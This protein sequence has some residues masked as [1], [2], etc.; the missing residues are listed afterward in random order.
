MSTN[1][2]GDGYVQHH[3]G[4]HPVI[5][6][7]DP[8]APAVSA[9]MFIWKRG[10]IGYANGTV[11]R[12]G[13][14]GTWV[15]TKERL[16]TLRLYGTAAHRAVDVNNAEWS[17]GAD[18]E[19]NISRP[20]FE[21]K[22]PAAPAPAETQDRD[23][24]EGVDPVID[25][26]FD[27]VWSKGADEWWRPERVSKA[28]MNV[29]LFAPNGAG[30][31]AGP[32]PASQS[33]ENARPQTAPV[34]CATVSGWHQEL[35]EAMLAHP[36]LVAA[37][38]PEIAQAAKRS[39]VEGTNAMSSSGAVIS[40]NCKACQQQVCD[41]CQGASEGAVSDVVL[42][43]SEYIDRSASTTQ[44]GAGGASFMSEDE[45]LGRS[46]QPVKGRL[47][48][49]DL[50]NGIMVNPAFILA[51]E[52]GGLA[53]STGVRD[54]VTVL[55]SN[56]HQYRFDVPFSH[57]QAPYRHLQPHERADIA[58]LTRRRIL[59]LLGSPGHYATELEMPP[60][61][62]VSPAADSPFYTS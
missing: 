47:D 26:E 54:G 32:V 3:N 14:D 50:G 19:W 34:G 7:V 49:I 62:L 30:C 35:C 51:V 20:E 58:E 2:I 15:D 46:P 31:V 16:N 45:W 36:P 22:H 5:D 29:N 11:W 1:E 59:A 27:M 6:I 37:M 40:C 25:R 53:T 4:E 57:P 43:R 18:G 21:V 33:S 24:L 56:G 8:D 38:D 55:M 41:V 9:V 42:D 17:M 10:A 28:A 61:E 39:Y 52:G 48:L 23:P 60:A 13:P 12:K 44:E